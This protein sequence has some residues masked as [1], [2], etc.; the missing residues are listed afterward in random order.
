MRMTLD[1]VRD[2]GFRFW[3]RESGDAHAVT[4]AWLLETPDGRTLGY[5]TGAAAYRDR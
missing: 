5:D 4:T 3:F 2:D 1:D